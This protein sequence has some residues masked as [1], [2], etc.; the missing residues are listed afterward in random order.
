MMTPREVISDAILF[1]YPSRR[2][3]AKSPRVSHERAQF[4]LKIAHLGISMEST[5]LR[6]PTPIMAHGN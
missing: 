3:V 1:V 5:Q 6:S 2:A 4:V